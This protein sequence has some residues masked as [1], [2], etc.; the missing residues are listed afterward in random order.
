MFL[1]HFTYSE[2]FVSR[3]RTLVDVDAFMIAFADSGEEYLQIR[4]SF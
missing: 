1:N 4:V 3:K 2:A